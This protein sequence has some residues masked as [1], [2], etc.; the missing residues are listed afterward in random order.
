[1]FR[2]RL[3]TLTVAAGLG[4]VCGCMSLSQFPLLERLRG[5]HASDC[6]DGG[7]LPESQ[8]PVMDGPVIQAASV[9]ALDS[10][11]Q[12]LEFALDDLGPLERPPLA[13]EL[14]PALALPLTN[15]EVELL[16]RLP[17]GGRGRRRVPRTCIHDQDENK[18]DN[19]VM[20]SGHD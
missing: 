19:P 4:L 16:H 20:S 7:V 10:Q 12:P 13:A 18:D 15:Q 17:L 5:R 11:Q 3:A 14:H 2:L 8:G 9:Q 1:M 6:C